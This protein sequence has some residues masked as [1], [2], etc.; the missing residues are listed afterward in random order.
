MKTMPFLLTALLFL[1]LQAADKPNIVFVLF[2]VMG[3]G[4]PQCYRADSKLKTHPQSL[5]P[6]SAVNSKKLNAGR[7]D[8]GMGTKE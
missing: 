1:P 2:D 7:N 5:C 4:Q 6:T 8:R 3:Y